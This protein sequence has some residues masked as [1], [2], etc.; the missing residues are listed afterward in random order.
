MI[1]DILAATFCILSFL[2][3]GLCAVAPLSWTDEAQNQRNRIHRMAKQTRHLRL[4]RIVAMFGAV[5]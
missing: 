5:R 3:L 4:G 2:V 1:L